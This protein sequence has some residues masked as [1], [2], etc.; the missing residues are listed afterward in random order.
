MG[1]D[2]PVVLKLPVGITETISVVFICNK[3]EALYLR[4]GCQIIYLKSKN[5][6]EIRLHLKSGS[7][8]TYNNICNLDVHIC[9]ISVSILLKK[10]LSNALKCVVRPESER[11]FM[12]SSHMNDRLETITNVSWI[13]DTSQIYSNYIDI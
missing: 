8:I 7:V 4:C 9:S 11:D 13:Q 6:S 3:Q 5:K 10:T 12:L 2:I 1:V